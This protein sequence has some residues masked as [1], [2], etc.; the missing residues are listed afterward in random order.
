MQFYL[1][2]IN[3]LKQSL[4]VL[5]AGERKWMTEVGGEKLGDEKGKSIIEKTWGI[6]GILDE[7]NTDSPNLAFGRFGILTNHFGIISSSI[8]ISVDEM[9]YQINIMEDIFESLNLS[10][11]LTSNDFY[12][13]MLWWKEDSIGEN[14]SLNSEVP[15][16][17]EEENLSPE[18]SPMKAH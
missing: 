6:V 11:V 10:S 1:E 9:P 17:L 15:I 13:R 2:E 4:S 7:C 16:Q 12:Q 18:S 14:E 3:N 5:V 8:T